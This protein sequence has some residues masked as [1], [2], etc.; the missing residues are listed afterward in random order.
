MTLISLNISMNHIENIIDYDVIIDF[1]FSAALIALNTC[2]TVKERF[3]AAFSVFIASSK[4]QTVRS[5]GK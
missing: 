4:L 3:S 1:N 5:I 2:S